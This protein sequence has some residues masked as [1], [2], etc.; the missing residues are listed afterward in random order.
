[1][2]AQ[3][4]T[5]VA[6]GGS[7]TFTVSFDPSALGPRNATLTIP[8]ADAP[9]NPFNFA[10]SSTGLGGGAGVLG[11]DSEGTFARNIDDSQIHGNRLIPAA[12]R[13][14]ELRAKVL[15]VEGAFKCAV[16]SDVNG[17]ADRLLR[18][19]E[20]VV[21]ATN[22]WNTFPLTEPLDLAAG[23]AYWL[24]IWSDTIGA[25][26]QAD[27]VGQAFQQT[28]F[29]L[30]LAGEWPDPISLAN[31]VSEGPRTYCIY[32][33]GTPLGTGPG[34]EIDVRGQGKLIVSGDATPSALDG[35]DFGTVSAGTGR[36]ERTFVIESRGE[37]A[38]ELSGD[39]RVVVTGANAGDFVV[40][41]APVSPVATGGSTEF[42]VSFQPQGTGLRAA[43]VR[44]ANGDTIENPYEFAVQ[45]AG[46]TVGRESLWPDTK[47]GGDV[48]FDGTYYE[49]GTIFRA[50]VPGTITHLRVYSLGAESGDHTARLW[51]NADETI[52]G[53]PYTWNYG[54]TTGWILL[55][56]E[57]V[58]IEAETEYTV[59]VSTGT[60]EKRNYPNVP[61]DFGAEGGNGEHLFYPISAGVFT[62]TAEGRPTESFNFGNYL[63]DIVFVPGGTSS[64]RLTAIE[65]AAN[66]ITLRWEGE[67][68]SFQVEKAAR[69]EGP[70]TV[71]ARPDG[72]RLY[73]AG[74]LASGAQA[75]YRIVQAP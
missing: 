62:T 39:P 2:T 42:I 20:E 30:D 40:T 16:Y 75:F 53:G 9:D 10:I 12:L 7:T 38:L 64:L 66:D 23:D 55:D 13:I 21:G 73:D 34:Q 25:R 37:T 69:I 32:A 61:A 50:S 71:S 49:L 48:N 68:P 67:G 59:S 19:S 14:T 70:F 22:G 33:E 18:S 60:S 43:T 58:A 51:R 36:Q 5:T 28:Y 11:N 54:G 56:I 41:S 17:F 52:I 8:H 27:P 65:A 6:G 4:A 26:V 24:V 46:V 44:I 3:P 1:M 35:T 47:V 57:D 45:G 15:A 63:R 74:A 31:P 72:T 29:Y